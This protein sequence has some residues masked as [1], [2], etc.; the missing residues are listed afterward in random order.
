[1]STNSTAAKPSDSSSSSYEEKRLSPDE[2]Y[3]KEAKKQAKAF[4]DKYLIKCGDSHIFAEKSGLFTFYYQGKGDPIWN[5]E[6][7][8]YPPKDLTPAE[9]LNGINPQPYEWRGKILITFPVFRC[10]NGNNDSWKDNYAV[11]SYIESKKGKWEVRWTPYRSLLPIKCSDVPCADINGASASQPIP[12]SNTNSSGS[13]LPLPSAVT[14]FYIMFEADDTGNKRRDWSRNGNTWIERYVDGRY[15][16]WRVVG[17][18]SVGNCSGTLILKVQG[19]G[20]EAFI[21]DKDCEDMSLRYR[22]KTKNWGFL[23][24]MQDIR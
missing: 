21:P 12:S 6:G 10:C 4:W 22:Y 11:D 15:H 1:M 5:V 7:Q 20:A 8:Y 9:K 23:G 14:S 17:R 13:N 18:S 16:E 2:Y 19:D 24:V 3:L